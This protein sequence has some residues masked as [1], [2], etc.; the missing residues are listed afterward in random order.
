MDDPLHSALDEAKAT[1]ARSVSQA[2]AD[3]EPVLRAAVTR[4]GLTWD[5]V[6]HRLESGDPPTL[7]A[8]FCLRHLESG[9]E[10]R[11]EFAIPLSSDEP[12][13]ATL[14]NALEYLWCHALREV[15]HVQASSPAGLSAHL[16]PT[17]KIPKITD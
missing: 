1:L 11:R 2:P 14:Q 13:D 5:L 17:L 15:L 4:A 12:T 16:Q 8:E 3:L 10:E 7:I 9:Q 6:S